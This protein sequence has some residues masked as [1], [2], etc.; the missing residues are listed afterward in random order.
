MKKVWP[1]AAVAGIGMVFLAQPIMALAEKSFPNKLLD[2]L[3]ILDKKNQDTCKLCHT[4]IKDPDTHRVAP[5]WN[6]FGLALKKVHDDAKAKTGTAPTFAQMFDAV[7]DLDSDGDGVSNIVELVAGT[8]PGDKDDKPTDAQIKEAQKKIDAWKA[9][10]AKD[11]GA[12][13]APDPKP[14]PPAPPAP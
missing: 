2:I 10:M 4:Q 5:K 11:G 8:K 13:P 14:L 1:F 9:Q 3:P 7:K 6:D 12:T